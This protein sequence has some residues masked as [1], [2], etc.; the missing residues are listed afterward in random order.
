MRCGDHFDIIAD[1]VHI[2]LWARVEKADGSG[3][4]VG[5]EHA[6]ITLVWN[7][8]IIGPR[9][10]GMRVIV[11]VV[12]RLHIHLPQKD[13]LSSQNAHFTSIVENSPVTALAQRITQDGQT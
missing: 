8:N 3:I 11:G 6:W 9:Q 7:R 2:R 4:R 1:G 10:P 13:P 12:I 5:P